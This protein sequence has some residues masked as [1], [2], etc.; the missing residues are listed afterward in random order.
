MLESMKRG[1]APHLIGKMAPEEIIDYF[2][3][4]FFN[5]TDKAIQD[6]LLQTAFLPKITIKA[7]EQLSGL[8][9]AGSILS[10][11]S[12]NNHFTE[13]HYSAEPVFQYHPLFREFLTA[14][15]RETFSQKRLSTL[16]RQS[17]FLLEEAGQIEAAFSIFRDL[18]DWGAMVRLILKEAPS[19]LAQGRYRTLEEWLDS[20]PRDL[21]EQDPWL[22]YWKGTSRFPFDPARAQS[23]LEQAFEQFGAQGN[24][25][26]ALLAWSGVVYS[27]IYR[28]EDYLPLDR[29]I[30]LFPALPQNPERVIP[31]EVWIQVVSSMFTALTYRR[32]EHGGTGIWIRRAESIVPEP[33]NPVAK[34]QILLQLVHH[35]LA[36]GDYEQ[37]SLGVRSLQHLA[38]SEEAAPFIIIMTRLAEAMHFGLTGDDEKCL[39]AV[40]DGLKTSE[41][42]GIYLLDNILVTHGVS[43][44]QNMGDLGTAQ[45]LLA[46]ID[47]SRDR[48]KPFE[49]GLYHFVQ[50]RQFL[51][52]SERSAAAAEV[53]FG[54]K[55]STEV[56]AYDGLCLTHLLIAQVMHGNGKHREAWGHL[57]E[58]FRIAKKVKSKV[59]EYYGFMIEA[60]FCLDQGEVTCGLASLRKAL[61]MGKEKRFLNTFVDQP[62]VTAK[63]CMKA[64]EE[65]IEVPYVQEII[66]KRRLIPEKPPLHLENWPW[67]LKMVTLG[68]F[69]LFVEGQPIKFSRKTQKKPLLLL[70]AI[71][72]L[73]GKNIDEERLS[74]I[75]WP[76]ADGDQAY[77]ALTTTL[78]RLRR[79]LGEKAL[80][81]QAGRVSLRLH[82]CWVDVWAFEHLI[83]KADDFWRGNHSA[84]SKDKA[85]QWMGKAVDLYQGPFL[86]DEGSELFWALPFRERLKNR[87]LFLIEKLGR[88]L[89]QT[90]QWE[91][92]IAHYQKG[93]EVDNLAEEIYRRLMACYGRLGETVKAIQVYQRLNNTLSSVLGVEPSPKTEAQYRVLTT[94]TKNPKTA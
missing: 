48:L 41:R 15:A 7:A 61:A 34:A 33:G 9:N 55:T 39:Q 53:K 46:K 35:Y 6:F 75:L 94:P 92:A 93:L 79:F 83:K 37:S 11:L 67:P 70:K 81:V 44:C 17:A 8:S 52:R 90:G 66:R 64:L 16:L 26:G 60:H 87:F 42:T 78:S 29:W 1:V 38:Q 58:A 65:G 27:I 3:N 77:S 89:E 10:T 23:Y 21:I 91:Q 88:S 45:S 68:R 36:N 19:I 57:Q 18:G 4:E 56:G 47:S 71:I 22:L 74:D 84:D 25:M 86:A 40:S 72:A 51:L 82:Y 13:R 49:K 31:P 43:C 28:F 80:E 2:G 20:L 59:F 76:E 24:T 85:L 30:Q 69:E 73:G 54:L 12:R 62:A 50:A 63:L 32:P 14:R 5:K